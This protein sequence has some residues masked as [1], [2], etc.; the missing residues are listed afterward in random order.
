MAPDKNIAAQ[1]E[2]YCFAALVDANKKN[3]IHRS[4]QKVPNT[5]V[6]RKSVHFPSIRV[7]FNCHR[8]K[9]NEIQRCKRN[10]INI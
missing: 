10:A 7:Q 6:Q 3:D 5:V 2:M 1:C 4:H 8:R 9:T